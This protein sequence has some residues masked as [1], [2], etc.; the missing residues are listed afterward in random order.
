MVHRVEAT[1]GEIPCWNESHRS[2]LDCTWFAHVCGRRDEWIYRIVNVDVVVEVVGVG[3]AQL[4]PLNRGPVTVSEGVSTVA[5]SLPHHLGEKA[6][7]YRG[8]LDNNQDRMTR[9]MRHSRSGR[10]C[11][12]GNRGRCRGCRWSRSSHLDDH[13]IPKMCFPPPV[14]KPVNLVLQSPFK[15]YLR[16]RHSL[17]N[18]SCPSIVHA[19]LPFKIPSRPPFR[20][21]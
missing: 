6:K 21:L 3:W 14:R 5:L 20:R 17:C 2:D 4:L 1:V 11:M 19:S 15:T 9:R 7:M 12:K 16:I 18:I 13:R 10:D 8:T